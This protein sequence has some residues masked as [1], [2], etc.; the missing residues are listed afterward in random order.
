MMSLKACY[1]SLLQL[2]VGFVVFLDHETS[3]LTI[4]SNAIGCELFNNIGDRVA[5]T[6]R[7]EPE[8]RVLPRH[9][10]LSSWSPIV[11]NAP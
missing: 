8:T 3:I 7:C 5:F 6:K 1:I 2:R 10:T 11:Q 9:K 4:C